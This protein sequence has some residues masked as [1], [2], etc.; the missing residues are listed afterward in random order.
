VRVPGDNAAE[1][2][3]REGIRR[4]ELVIQP[5]EPPNCGFLAIVDRFDLVK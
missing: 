3:H 5:V 2:C 1:T 4:A